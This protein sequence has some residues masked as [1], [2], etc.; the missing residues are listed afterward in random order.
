MGGKTLELG[1]I[2]VFWRKVWKTHRAEAQGAGSP[3]SCQHENSGI[4]GKTPPKKPSWDCN[5]F[6]DVIRAG[7][8]RGFRLLRGGFGPK[9]GGVDEEKHSEYMALKLGGKR[10]QIGT[11]SG[12]EFG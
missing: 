1:K 5:I 2:T 7:M 4:K 10:P 9:N 6:A 11:K 3:W 12:P 8:S